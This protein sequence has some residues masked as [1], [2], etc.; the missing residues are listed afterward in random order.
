M[1]FVLRLP[2]AG[3]FACTH[4]FLF[5]SPVGDILLRLRVQCCTMCMVFVVSYVGELSC[6]PH[7][8]VLF[9]H[10]LMMLLSSAY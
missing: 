6:R 10:M 7:V 1:E 8:D 2:V 3:G 4:L 5:F 9:V